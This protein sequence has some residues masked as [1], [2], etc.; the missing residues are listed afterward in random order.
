MTYLILSYK[1]GNYYIHNQKITNEEQADLLCDTMNKIDD[2]ARYTVVAIP[3]EK[4]LEVVNN[5]K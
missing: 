2:G 1:Y 4:N 5:E 3:E